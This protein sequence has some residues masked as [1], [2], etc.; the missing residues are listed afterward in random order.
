ME[1]AAHTPGNVSLA[2]P[3]TGV[4]PEATGVRMKVPDEMGVEDGEKM[5]ALRLVAVV[6]EPP[7][8]DAG[9]RA[10]CHSPKQDE[11][12]NRCFFDRIVPSSLKVLRT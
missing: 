2:D 12:G 4:E 5:L 6:Y 1:L 10:S 11:W 9:S 7:V 3:N 8:G